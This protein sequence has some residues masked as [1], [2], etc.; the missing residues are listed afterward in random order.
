VLTPDN[1]PVWAVSIHL[2]W[3]F[4]YEQSE[5]SRVIA[6]HLQSLDGPVLIGGDF[7]MVPWGASVRL[8]GDAAGNVNFGTAENTHI[9]GGRALPLSIDNLLF[10][11]GTKGT[12]E[13][14]PYMGSDHLG[15]LARF[16]L[17]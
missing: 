2:K 7:N 17:Q 9:L 4:P 12:V 10:P 8:I 16:Q 5:Q 15:K 13:P 1:G 11:K 6:H 3:P 14:R